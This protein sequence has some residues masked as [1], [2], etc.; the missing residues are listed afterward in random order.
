[1]RRLDGFNNDQLSEL[2]MLMTQ[3]AKKMNSSFSFKNKSSYEDPIFRKFLETTL[4][5]HQIF[6]L[7]DVDFSKVF[8]SNG[9]MSL[10]GG[11][12]SSH[13]FDIVEQLSMYNGLNYCPREKTSNGRVFEH[14]ADSKVLIDHLIQM[15]DNTLKEGGSNEIQW[16]IKIVEEHASTKDKADDELNN[17]EIKLAEKYQKTIMDELKIRS[18]NVV[19]NINKPFI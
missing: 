19:L 17:N 2:K 14:A 4:K 11:N 13:Y 1:V 9:T 12:L 18:E 8:P 6:A 15:Q 10:R 7:V 16:Y 3:V 5:V